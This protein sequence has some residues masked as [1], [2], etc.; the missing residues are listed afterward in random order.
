MLK[1]VQLS[2]LVLGAHF[3]ADIQMP[4]QSHKIMVLPHHLAPIEIDQADPSYCKIGYSTLGLTNSGSGWSSR[5]AAVQLPV[6]IS[7]SQLDFT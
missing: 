7:H 3:A 1:Q 4:C 6:S 5:D 2:L